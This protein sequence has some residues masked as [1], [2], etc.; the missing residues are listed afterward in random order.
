[1]RIGIPKLLGR[2]VRLTHLARRAGSG[3]GLALLAVAWVAASGLLRLALTDNLQPDDAELVISAQELRGGYSDQPPLYTWMLWAVFRVTGPGL[4]GLG[5]VRAAL[6]LALF[7]LTYRTAKLL[8][9]DRRLAAPLAFSS[10]LLPAYG[11]HVATYLTHSLLLGVAVMGTV[12]AAARVV[13]F[14]ATRD[15][16]LL[17]V[18]V[19]VG[20]LAKYN[21]PL[22]V[23]AA[24]GAGLAVPAA[25]VRLLDRRVLLAA[26]VALALLAPHLVWLAGAWEDVFRLVRNKSNRAESPPYWEGVVQGLWAA[27]VCLAGCVVI[28]GPLLAWLGRQARPVTPERPEVAWLGW[29]LAGLALLHIALV[30]GFGVTR[31]QDRWVQ[32][33]LLP[34]PVWYLARFAPGAVGRWGVPV[35]AWI[36]AGLAAAVLAGQ[37]AQVA[38]VDRLPGRYDLQLDYPRLAAELDAAGFGNATFVA[39]D[40]EIIG[41][42]LPH[43]PGVTM[44]YPAGVEPFRRPAGTVVLLWDA[45]L[46]ENLPLKLMP[47]VESTVGEFQ[48]RPARLRTLTLHSRNP[49]GRPVGVRAYALPAKR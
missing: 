24:A 7:G 12:Y 43:M 31:F 38:L 16:A 3:R 8:V 40:R 35:L 46:G 47:A 9:P 33:L 45:Q 41:N 5:V 14:G 29:F 37:V 6:L 18:A 27:V 36:T 15:Y 20:A 21:F 44:Q 2:R 10:L 26:G 30:F 11:W 17:G 19:G 4:V 49:N 32:P 39:I 25:R 23:A 1:M 34:L 42:L 13:R 28:V 22:V 48:F